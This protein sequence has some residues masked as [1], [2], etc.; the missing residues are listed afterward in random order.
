MDRCSWKLLAEGQVVLRV[1]VCV[2]DLGT[3]T[4]NGGTLARDAVDLG[5]CGP[6]PKALCDGGPDLDLDDAEAC[7]FLKSN[8]DLDRDAA[9]DP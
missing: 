5:T 1:C 7:V 9:V 6:S 3:D 8:G 2:C 4:V